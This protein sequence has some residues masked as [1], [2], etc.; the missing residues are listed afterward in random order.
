MS[1]IM[2]AKEHSNR[3]GNVGMMQNSGKMDGAISWRMES[4]SA[5]SA[6]RLWLKSYKKLIDT[7][8]KDD[9][10]A[11]TDQLRY[12]LFYITGNFEEF[13]VT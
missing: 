4:R 1:L 3:S 8:K 10:L 5:K 2:P 6:A 7:Q 11:G 9:I 12:R 13:P